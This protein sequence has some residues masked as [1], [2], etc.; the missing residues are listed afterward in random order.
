MQVK[1]LDDLQVDI[2]SLDAL[3]G[4]PDVDAPMRQRVEL[5]LRLVKAGAKAERDAEYEIEFYTRNRTDVATIHGLRIEITGRTAA[6]D[7]IIMN[8]RL[9]IWLCE[10]KSVSEA[11]HINEHGERSRSY[12]GER[13]EMPSP[14]EQNKH[15]VDVIEDVLVGLLNRSTSAGQQLRPR[16]STLVVISKRGRIFRPPAGSQVDGLDTVIKCDLLMSKIKRANDESIAQPVVSMD[17]VV[18]SETLKGLADKLVSLHMPSKRDWAA[19]FGLPSEPP[20]TLFAADSARAP[21]PTSADPAKGS[22]V[23][24]GD[25]HFVCAECRSDVSLG[26]AKYCRDKASLFGGRI[27][28]VPCQKQITMRGTVRVGAERPR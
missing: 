1:S 24:I 10:S 16:I 13:Q 3:A 23:R 26:V 17:E 7:H 14:I 28:C 6:I 12:R 11:I 5:M 18:T 2:D 25:P 19:R 8:R 15:H 20:P 4:R 21:D 9:Q 27:L 22:V